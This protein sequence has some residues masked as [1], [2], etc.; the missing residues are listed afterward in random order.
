MRHLTRWKVVAGSTTAA[1]LAGSAIAIAASLPAPLGPP[2]P[3]ELTSVELR[4]SPTD[5]ETAVPADGDAS[6][7]IEEPTSTSFD[8]AIAGS[9]VSPETSV[10]QSDGEPTISSEADSALSASS[11]SSVEDLS[12]DS[13]S[14]IDS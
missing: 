4:P 7:S 14:S 10:R 3:I 2:A 11:A 12:I 1:A 9:I 8:D 6:D 5:D 13:P